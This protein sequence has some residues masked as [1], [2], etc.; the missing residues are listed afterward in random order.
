MSQKARP[1]PLSNM[2]QVPCISPPV[3]RMGPRGAER[4]KFLSPLPSFPGSQS[5]RGGGGERHAGIKVSGRYGATE[6]KG[7]LR[8]GSKASEISD[9][10]QVG[11]KQGRACRN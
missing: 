11:F 6:V 4:T 5:R 3:P 8:K 9:G 7:K 2:S 10:L 1:L